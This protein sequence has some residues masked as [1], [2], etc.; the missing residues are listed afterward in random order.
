MMIWPEEMSCIHLFHNKWPDLTSV[1]GDI[2]KGVGLSF[3]CYVEI[4]DPSSVNHMC[5]QDQ[6]IKYNVK[7]WDNTGAS[8]ELHPCLGYGSIT[9]EH[10]RREANTHDENKTTCKFSIDLGAIVCIP[11]VVE[12]SFSNLLRVM[13][14]RR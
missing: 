10:N 8:T 1:S 14:A 4:T 7:G 3:F 12:E 13:K 2:L 5:K 9:T 6:E 11:V